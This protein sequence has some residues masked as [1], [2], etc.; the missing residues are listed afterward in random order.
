MYGQ[1]EFSYL[2]LESGIKRLENNIHGSESIIFSTPSNN[3]VYRIVTFQEIP[4]LQQKDEL[5][6]AGVELI[7][8]LPKMAYYARIWKSLDGAELSAL[9]MNGIHDIL[10]ENKLATAVK[11]AEV[12]DH[13]IEGQDW[14][15]NIRYFQGVEQVKIA[16]QLKLL[17]AT[18]ISKFSS[19]WTIQISEGS[20]DKLI[21]IEEIY[22]VSFIPEVGQPENI[23][24]RLDHR[25]NTL[26]QDI[27]GGLQYNG[28]GIKVMLQD[29]GYLGDHIDYKGRVDQG[30]CSGC[31]TN[32]GNDHGDHVAGTIMGAGNLNP[33]AKGMA[34]GAYIY[35]FGSD[36]INYDTVPAL[37]TDSGVVI[38]S[39]SY[40]NG[41]NA[42]YSDLAA[43]LD[44]QVHNLPSLTHVFSAGNNGSS[45]CAYGA[46]AGWGNI[47]GGH[48]SGKNVITVGNLTQQDVIAPSSSR[49]PMTDGRIKPDICA[50]GTSV[51]STIPENSYEF[52]TGTSMSCPGVSGTVAQ[53]YQAYKDLNSG[54]NPPAGL[55]KAALLNSA[56]DLG[57]PGPDFIHGYGRINARRAYEVLAN[58]NYIADTANQGD[59]DIFLLNVP[60]G[61][62]ELKIMIYW[63]DFEGTVGAAYALVNDINLKVKDPVATL[64]EPWVLDHTPDVSSLS[65]DAL[66]KVDSLNNVEQVTILDPIPGTYE[67]DVFGDLIPEGPQPYFIV[68]QMTNDEIVI[69]HPN[70]GEGIKANNSCPIRWD[71]SPSTENFDLEYTLDNG[72]NWYNIGTAGANDRLMYWNTPGDTITGNAKIRISR[73]AVLD[74]SDTVFTLMRVANNL[75]IEWKCPDSL[76]FVWDSIPGATGYEI[77]MLGDKY[78]DSIAVSATNSVVLMLNENLDTWLTVRGLGP[79]NARSERAIAVHKEPGQYACVWSDPVAQFNASCDKTG[80]FGCVTIDNT[81]MNIDTGSVV[82]WYFPGGT[83]AT[84]TDYSPVVCYDT[85]GNKDAALVVQNMVG[86]DSIY[87]NNFIVVNP[88]ETIAYLEGFE[89]LDS[90]G[91]TIDWEVINYGGNSFIITD[92]AAHTGAKSVMLENFGESYGEVDELISGPIDLS[93]LD[94]G[95]GESVTL[96]FRYAYRRVTGDENENLT[97][98]VRSACDANWAARK[99]IG[100]NNLSTFL[101]PGYYVPSSQADWVTVHVVN[102]T[103]GYWSNNFQMMFQFNGESGNNFYLDDI[104]IYEGVPSE[105]LIGIEEISDNN[106]TSPSLFPNPSDGESILKFHMIKAA[107]VS[108]RITDAAGRLISSHSILANEGENMVF[109]DTEHLNTGAYHIS[110]SD[111][112]SN[113]QIN[114]IKL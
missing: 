63:P 41:C 99:I 32:P 24:G 114:Y 21:Q 87:I 38:T 108:V 73:G 93:G 67:I 71:A 12:P 34:H 30:F 77:S 68:Y 36:N 29:D 57:N 103:S 50:V 96:S 107:R 10:P 109:L 8:Y 40:S 31:S 25:S 49:G 104:N 58:N 1:Q 6:N 98:L 112:N 44:Q 110:I 85:N 27:D 4:S 3:P 113:H 35:V 16:E 111:E 23:G 51:Y 22:H 83:P 86:T 90:L 69:T 61:T 64:F 84:S 91:T 78:M 105:E 97:V 88:V 81:S 14:L 82:T 79:D 5:K 94:E 43:Q 76:K 65:A 53:L 70:G 52:K 11:L 74:E 106:I 48:K 60:S 15:M 9:G 95:A 17:G 26:A 19:F 102:I 66:R 92:N 46:G 72:L 54:A 28:E 33:L 13:A 47:T 59:N 100:G 89:Y 2:Y 39:K 80:T 7:A 45:N 18:I 55:I 42:G 56:E 37:Y 101:S 75:D 62:K 20:I